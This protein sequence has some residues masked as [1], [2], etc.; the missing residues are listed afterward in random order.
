MNKNDALQTKL[1]FSYSDQK[2]SLLVGGGSK[3]DSTHVGFKVPIWIWVIYL[4][5]KG[6]R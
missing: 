4:E 1:C 2:M 3:V 6:S 5:V